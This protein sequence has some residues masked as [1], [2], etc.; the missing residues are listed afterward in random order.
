MFHASLAQVVRAVG[1][2]M[3]ETTDFMKEVRLSR[4]ENEWRGGRSELRSR[5]IGRLHRQTSRDL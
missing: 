3:G 4:M 2:Y 5:E 1:V